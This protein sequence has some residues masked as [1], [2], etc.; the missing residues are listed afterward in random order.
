[1]ASKRR[2]MFHKNKTQETTEKGRMA[3]KRWSTNPA[4]QTDENFNRV[5]DL[6][7]SVQLIA[8]RLN[9]PKT[10][11]HKVVTEKINMRKVCAKLTDEQKIQ[12][13]AVASEL[14]ERIEMEPDFFLSMPSLF[15]NIK[16]I[17]KGTRF[18]K[19]EAIQR[20]TTRALNEV[21]VEA[22]QDA[23]RAWQIVSTLE[24]NINRWYRYF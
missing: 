3:G 17:I 4:L 22:F 5:R 23:Y 18:G 12:R 6:L 11:F 15:P 13:V 20:A 8:N 9:N 24:D 7:N 10:I 14:P 19:I 21:A 1:M 2:N 16:T